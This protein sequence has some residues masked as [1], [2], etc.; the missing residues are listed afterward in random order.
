MVISGF[1]TA[2]VCTLVV[3]QDP[4]RLLFHAAMWLAVRPREESLLQLALQYLHEAVRV[5]VVMDTAAR[6][7][8]KVQGKQEGDQQSG[9]H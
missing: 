1:L 8:R 7:D 2:D 3:L 9:N 6:G 5:G 4:L